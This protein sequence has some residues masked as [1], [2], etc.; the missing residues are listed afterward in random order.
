MKLK[1]ELN[2][3]EDDL[4]TMLTSTEVIEKFLVDSTP[5]QGISQSSTDWIHELLG[6]EE[7]I[8][9]LQSHINL[10]YA[11]YDHVWNKVAK[12]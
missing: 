10:K 8:R 5:Q 9:N 1:G 7:F 2:E 12:F 4:R 6:T 3:Q 11:I